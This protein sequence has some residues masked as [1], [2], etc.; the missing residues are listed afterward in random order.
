M[1]YMLYNF[2]KEAT[3]EKLW[4]LFR[5]FGNVVDVYMARKKL[6]NGKEFGFVIFTNVKDIR[7]LEMELNGVWIGLFKI[8]VFPAWDREENTKEIPG[9]VKKDEMIES[10]DQ[11]FADL[12][13]TKTT[14]LVAGRI[15]ISTCYEFPLQKEIIIKVGDRK[16]FITV[17][18]EGWIDE[19]EEEDE[20]SEDESSLYTSEEEEYRGDGNSEHNSD[21]ISFN[22]LLVDEDGDGGNRIHTQEVDRHQAR[23]SNM[24]GSSIKEGSDMGD[25][26]R[27]H[28]DNDDEGLNDDEVAE[29]AVK[30][31]CDTSRVGREE[32]TQKEP[33]GPEAMKAQLPNVE[34]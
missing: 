3:V 10:M 7:G 9:R 12:G 17:K 15:L 5:R 23:Y 1:S 25:V 2:H 31:T 28:R 4:S 24:S 11:I 32:W 27:L 30:D 20:E 8:R 18:D 26:N 34:A 22:G 6:G 21:N 29:V 33:N 16:V 14:T 19:V 13:L